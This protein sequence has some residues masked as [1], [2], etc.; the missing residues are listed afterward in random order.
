M[1]TVWKLL[2]LA[3]ADVVLSGHD[4]HYERFALQD[5]N[6]AA[7]PNNGIRQFIVGT[8]GAYPS[9]VFF[10]KSQSEIVNTQESGVLKLTL[11][12][13]SYAWQFLT[14]QDGSFTDQG[15][16]ACHPK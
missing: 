11:N 8:V 10:R 12:Q 6:G 5:S 16:A 14:V 1:L 2:M 7:D 3:K 13:G 4:H 9:P 15:N